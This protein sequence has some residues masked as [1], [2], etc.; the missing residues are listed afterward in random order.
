MPIEAQVRAQ[1]M[2]TAVNIIQWVSI[3]TAV[4]ILSL[5]HTPEY[6]VAA[7]SIIVGLHLLPL[8]RSLRHAQHYVTGALLIAWPLGCLALL[9][10]PLVSGV[11]AL[12]IGVVLLLSAVATL[13]HILQATRTQQHQWSVTR[14]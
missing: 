10:R 12:G 2:F 9:P 14:G 6:I 1:R 8:A 3:A 5:L 7:I 4:A 11:C 13:L